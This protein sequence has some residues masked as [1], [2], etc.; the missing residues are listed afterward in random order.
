MKKKKL[1]SSLK[2]ALASTIAVTSAAAIVYGTPEI[3]KTVAAES[4]ENKFVLDVEKID[5]DTIK[6]SLDNIED[7]PRAIQ[8]SIN[9]NGVVIKEE[10]RSPIIKDLINKDKSNSI[11]TDYTYNK[12]ANTVDV[13]VTSIDDLPKIGNKVEIFELDIE[14]ASDNNDKTYSVTATDGSVYKY[15]STTNKEY[16]SKDIELANKALSINTAPTIKKKNGVSYI[17]INVGEKLLLT[18]EEL[19]KYIEVFDADGDALSLEVKDRD[20]NVITEFSNNTAGIYDLYIIAT[21]NYESTEALN[22]QIKVNAKQEN[23]IITRNEEELKDII[24][25]S[26][27]FDTLESLIEYLQAGVKAIDIDNNKLDVNIEVDENIILNP[28]KTEN[29]IIT[30]KAK[31]SKDR[32]TIKEIVLTIRVNTA[33][34]IIGVKDHVLT[35]GDEFDPRKDVTVEDDYDK[36]LEVKIQGT[37]DTSKAGEYTLIYTVT[38][39]DGALTEVIS[40]VTVKSKDDNN[41]GGNGDTSTPGEDIE[42]AGD[43]DT[44]KPGEDTTII[45]PD[46]IENIIDDKVISKVSGEATI[47]NPLVLDIQ[48]VSL[49]EFNIFID[50]LKDLNPVLIEKYNNGNY[51]IYK[52]KLE[53]SQNLI[54]RIFSFRRVNEEGIVEIRVLNTLDY[55]IEFNNILD[56]LLNI[57]LDDDINQGGN[58]E[59]TPEESTEDL[60]GIV[61]PGESTEGGNGTGT[62]GNSIQN[63]NIDNNAQQNDNKDENKNNNN[64]LP[65]TGQESML[66]ILGFLAVAIGGVIYKKKK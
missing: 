43:S 27:Q 37:V 62:S 56:E 20:N 11:I 7:I 17:E 57:N 19:S 29:Y 26:G 31:D 34:V 33:P 24:I 36:N 9:L 35:V 23:P 60:S 48:N 14:K 15:V 49:D 45:V 47:E 13:L 63:G 18:K 25:K 32:E 65:I 12:E 10:N 54:Q 8:F 39:S 5:G 3:I 41:Q 44:S 42:Q 16:V 59:E 38:D 51:T 46:F 58:G 50:K 64:K 28:E 66:G 6:V 40:K 55:V 53:N 52:M 61:T 21:D 30:Y 2:V 1:K 22:L 4:S